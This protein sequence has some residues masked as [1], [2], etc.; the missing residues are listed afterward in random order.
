MMLIPLLAAIGGGSLKPVFVTD[1]SESHIHPEPRLG[2]RFNNDGSIDRRINVVGVPTYS[3][4][5]VG[6]WTL[7]EP[8]PGIGNSYEIR[9]ASLTTGTW[10]VEAAAVGVWVAL[11]A[12]REWN[13]LGG[14]GGDTTTGQFEIGLVGASTALI[15]FEVSIYSESP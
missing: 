11:T 4:I 14:A 9:Q 12:D 15:S 3:Q 1:I 10:T 7:V 2:V 6:E 13:L 5:Q 8:L